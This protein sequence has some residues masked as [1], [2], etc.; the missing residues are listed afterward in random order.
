M[1]ATGSRRP[2]TKS[3]PGAAT[4][5]RM[6]LTPSE[7]EAFLAQR[8]TVVVATLRRDG[9]PHLTT[10]WYRWDGASFWISTNRTTAK[11]RHIV[12]DPRVSLLIDAPTEETSIAAYGRAEIVTQ[13]DDAWDGAMEIVA[14]YVE[15]AQAYLEAR[16]DEPR[17]LIRVTPRKLVSWKP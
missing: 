10:V 13:D 12:R 9:A 17:A 1:T 16:R 6:R 8:H 4:L 5:D 3:P 14:R 15:D 7:I 11:Y 2:A